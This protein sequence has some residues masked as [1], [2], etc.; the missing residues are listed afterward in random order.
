[1]DKMRWAPRSNPAK[2]PMRLCKFCFFGILLPIS[3]LCVPL[4]MRFVSLRPFLFTLSPLDMKLL[5]HEH[6]VSTIW[7][8]AQTIRMNSTFNAYLLPSKPKLLRKR[9]KVEMERKIVDLEDDMKEYWG[10]FLLADSYF[11]LQACS[12]HEGASVVVIK[13]TK[14]VAK[15]AWLGELDSAEE[16]DEM[17]SEFDFQQEVLGDELEVETDDASESS[18]H[19]NEVNTHQSELLSKNSREMHRYL[20]NI[21]KWSIRS[22]KTVIKRLMEQIVNEKHVKEEDMELFENVFQKYTSINAAPKLSPVKNKIDK[23]DFS[24]EIVDEIKDVDH[25]L[26]NGKFNQKNRMN[27]KEDKSNEEPRS[28]WSSSEEAL[29]ACEGAVFNIALNG[30]TGCNENSTFENMKLIMSNMEYVTDTSGFYYFIFTNENEITS[31]F[32]AASFEMHKTIFDVREAEDMCVNSTDCSLHLS[33]LSHQHV[34]I[35]VPQRENVGCDYEAEGMTNYY[36]C[37]T[38][39]HAES[40]CE[41]R[42]S[43]YFIFLLLV[44]ALILIFAYV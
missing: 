11:R 8:S 32:V 37:N 35:E 39:I 2:G 6:T 3:L 15:C 28:S 25:F 42:G 26:D 36:Q 4:Y 31:N 9:Q 19:V 22:R 30:A 21:E 13:H 44:P 33:F 18:L 43:I 10:F 16:S 5:N 40:V 14:N 23:E 24:G 20:D 17:S 41:P 38:I 1:M 27:N 7:C 12:R 34:V 29:A